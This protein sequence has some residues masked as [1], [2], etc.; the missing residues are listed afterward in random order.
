[1]PCIKKIKILIRLLYDHNDKNPAWKIKY[2]Y[3]VHFVHIIN[4]LFCKYWPI[5]WSRLREISIFPFVAF[6]SIFGNFFVVCL[7]IVPMCDRIHWTLETVKTLRLSWVVSSMFSHS[8][9]FWQVVFKCDF[10]FLWETIQMSQEQQSNQCQPH[11]LPVQRW[12][13]KNA[14]QRNKTKD[15]NSLFEEMLESTSNELLKSCMMILRETGGKRD[16]E[17]ADNFEAVIKDK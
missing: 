5:L 1:M 4:K 6:T 14:F 16:S 9:L 7:T 10:H 12:T 15:T 11:L 8:I 17:R 3:Y 2:P 13:C